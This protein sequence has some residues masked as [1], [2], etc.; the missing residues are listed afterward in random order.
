MFHLLLFQTSVGHTSSVADVEA[1]YSTV[2]K[3]KP[4]NSHGVKNETKIDDYEKSDLITE[5]P[6]LETYEP[7][8]ILDTSLVV[9]NSNVLGSQSDVSTSDTQ[10][11]QIDYTPSHDP[12][13][14][15]V[16]E[17]SLD[18]ADMPVYSASVYKELKKHKENGNIHLISVKDTN[19][20]MPKS[21]NMNFPEGSSADMSP[22]H[23]AAASGDKKVL[24]QLLAILPITQDPVEMV[25]G[26]EKMCTR[27]GLEVR[28]SEGRTP[29]MHAV[30][31]NHVHSVKMLAE[32]GANVNTI[33]N[34]MRQSSN[35]LSTDM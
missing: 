32:V 33:A 14:E 24:V 7:Q 16:G 29:I 9:T 5:L 4:K 21:Q 26:T 10:I 13:Y 6:K 30:H 15:I 18:I 27:Q 19:T 8:S 28:D 17:P 11:E 31:N 3:P 22:L 1:L 12:T 34:G 2:V 25:L 23:Y 35:Y 20:D